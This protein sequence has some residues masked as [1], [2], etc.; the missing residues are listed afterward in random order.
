MIHLGTATVAIIDAEELPDF[1]AERAKRAQTAQGAHPRSRCDEEA[2]PPAMEKQ[3][4]VTNRVR[5]GALST[6]TARFFAGSGSSEVLLF[7][8]TKVPGESTVASSVS[9]GSAADAMQQLAIRSIE[10]APTL[11]CRP[12]GPMTAPLTRDHTKNP[13]LGHGPNASN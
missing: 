9:C 6:C 12:S 2:E 5:G 7:L 3:R 10:M 4:P 8:V 13:G 1:L 11:G